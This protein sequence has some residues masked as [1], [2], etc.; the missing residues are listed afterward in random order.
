MDVALGIH[1]DGRHNGNGL[2]MHFAS[3]LFFYVDKLGRRT[4]LSDGV[5][6]FFATS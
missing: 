4:T 2:E 3:L 5:V 1:T 6:E